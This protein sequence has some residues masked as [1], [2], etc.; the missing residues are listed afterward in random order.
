MNWSNERERV[1]R[2]LRHALLGPSAPPK[3]VAGATHLNGIKPLE[4]FQTGILFPI[5]SD[6]FGL[7]AGEDDS[8]GPG[9]S[10][11]EANS[12]GD[13]IAFA[14]SAGQPQRRVVPP[15][16]VG[17]S[18]FV[19]GDR[20]ELQLIPTAVRYERRAD[21][22]RDQ[23][24]QWLRI[25]L[26]EA[27][28]EARDVRAPISA[29]PWARIRAAPVVVFDGR[30]RLDVLWRARSDGWLITVSLSN[31]QAMPA[32]ANANTGASNISAGATM[33]ALLN[34]Q[35]ERALFEVALDCV[36]DRGRV[37]P[38]PRADFHLLD[39]E[40]QELELRYRRQVIYAIGHGAAVDWALREDRVVRIHTEFLPKVE[41]PRV[42]PTAGVV[43]GAELDV[44]RLAAIETD[45]DRLCD[46]LERFAAGYRTWS[47]AQSKVADG[48]EV[49]YQ[50]PADRI[51]ARIE[52]A[53][54]RMLAGV[55]L[56]RQEPLLLHAF[57]LA[58]QAMARQM[59]QAG[60][61]APRWRPFQL[62]FL[63]LTLESATDP[64]AE[65]RDVLDLIWFP[66]G[67]GKTEAYLGLMA[68]VI[69]WRRLKYKA[70]GGGTTVLMRYTLRLLTK[71]QFRRAAR[72][73]CA[74][75]LMR[76]EQPG[77]LGLEPITLGLWVGG[78][79]SPN[80][81]A[82][83]KACIDA[84]LADDCSRPPSLLVLESCPWCGTPF[85]VPDNLDASR[86]HF[87]FRCTAAGCAFAATGDGR[88]P[89]NLVDAALYEAPPT[90]LL[91][92]IDKFARLAW[93]ERSSA[94]F[95]RNGQRPPE[96]IIQDELHLIA[97]AL[98]S[99]AGLYEAGL[100]TVLCRRGVYPKYI[101][102]T[103]TIRMA[104]EQVRRLY[105]REAA[106][107]PPPGLDADDAYF[108]RTIAPT[109]EH[110][111]RLYV[112]YL[113]PARNRRRCL[114]PLAAAL[115]SAPEALFGDLSADRE[116]LLDAWWTLLVYHG[117]LSGIGISRHALREIEERIERLQREWQDLQAQQEQP[118]LQGQQE[119]RAEQVRR[120]HQAHQGRQAQKR[121][122]AH[123]GRQA[124][125]EQQGRPEQQA[126]DTPDQQKRAQQAPSGEFEQ[127]SAHRRYAGPRW[128]TQLAERL[129]QLTSQMSADE[130]AQ[131]FE[132]LA[133]SR[134]APDALDLA[135]ATNMVSVGLD[136]SRLAVMI[137]NGQPLT[138]AEYIQ[139]SSRV[140]R[141]EV[142]GIVVANYYRDQARSLS[143]Y[144][145][146]RAYHQ[147]F[148]RFVEPTSVTPYTY[149]ARL[150]ALHAALV[151]A[152]RHASDALT[153][154]ERAQAFDPTQ[155]E[156]AKVIEALIRRTRQADPE[157]AD[158]T[159]AHLRRLVAHWSDCARRASEQRQRLVYS[160]PDRD[161]RDLRLLSAHGA[162]VTGE[163]VTLQ[164][165]RNVEKTALIKIL[166][167]NPSRHGLLAQDG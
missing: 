5:A 63:L 82:D 91:A 129:A 94:F 105:G 146:F 60:R 165:M 141:G 83:A 77:G 100:E 148:Y 19:Q 3:A 50:A 142:P 113:A 137:I 4:R 111:G 92:T 49:R 48:L 88:L 79:S 68:L 26:G 158:Q 156:T 84:A 12:D 122:Q 159:E 107:F 135:L 119:W 133:K 75:E 32:A 81:F 23:A 120:G 144:E 124:K 150:R 2:W 21:R 40:E 90:L 24:D 69:W 46:A 6:E 10:L 157:R 139:A 58:N 118:E 30:A 138:T 153:A 74:M 72:L 167:T 14:S 87:A 20:A 134:E 1:Y 110:P 55:A 42:D 99:V 116:A 37:G 102:S 145:D 78:D 115:L 126:H 127:A 86:Q 62:A 16:S 65:H 45:R 89:C 34:Q 101:A 131:G 147:A 125:Q 29:R 43:E 160:G 98:G 66:T 132:R 31:L 106:V 103:A 8:G 154:N 44:E 64:D 93:E 57:A 80:S 22:P 41:V 76:R 33:N 35:N 149:Q 155:P 96:L 36:I 112:G 114:A 128:R 73:I 13:K 15:A 47:D 143:H 11:D 121:E 151:I 95:G 108:A 9:S 38:Y 85:R 56:L 163:W 130:N 27:D 161:R 51:R 109:P 117:S 104:Q 123:E 7:D 25:P 162:R 152:V 97:G 39:E 71:D 70:S 61:L 59:R 67:G 52:A 17:F 166:P 18:F 28:S 54:E 136:V 53:A 164:N 140:G